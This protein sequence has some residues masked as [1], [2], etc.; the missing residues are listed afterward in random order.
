MI[1]KRHTRHARKRMQQRAISDTQIRLI[2]MFGEYRYQKGGCH[3][4]N[5]PEKVLT[6]LRAAVDKLSNVQAIYSDSDQLITVM[7]EIRNTHKTDYAC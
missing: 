6:E 2:E 7:H 3:L 5:I 1:S 4:A